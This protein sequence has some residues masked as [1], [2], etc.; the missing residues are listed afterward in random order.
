MQ[1]L[2]RSCTL[3]EPVAEAPKQVHQLPLVLC[4]S[5]CEPDLTGAVFAF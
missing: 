3:E 5:I 4:A 1:G 2:Q